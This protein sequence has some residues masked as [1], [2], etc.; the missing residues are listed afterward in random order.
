MSTK[1]I[2]YS[3]APPEV[4]EIYD[5]ILVTRKTDY[6][7]NMWKALALHPPTLRRTWQSVKE[8][9][10]GPGQLDPIVRELIYLAVSINNSCEYCMASHTA[11]ARSKGATEE[12]LN[13]LKAIIALANNTNRLAVGYQIPVDERYRQ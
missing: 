2:E 9:M 4:R 13:E 8:V 7:N 1:L 5:D 10:S 12:M 6:I 11:A 3:E